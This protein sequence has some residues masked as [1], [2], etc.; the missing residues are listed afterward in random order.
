MIK[1]RLS[2]IIIFIVS[3]LFS[4][5][6]V[7]EP[8]EIV[9]DH[10]RTIQILPF[11][12]KTQQIRL[13]TD[14][15]EEV[16]NEF[17]KEGRLTV[18]S[19]NDADSS[20]ETSIIEYS[21]IPI[22]YDENFIAQEYKLK[23]ILNLKFNDHINRVKLWEDVREDLSGGIETSIK[24]YVGQEEEFAET[25]EEAKQRLIQDAA[26]QILQRTIYGWEK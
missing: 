2:I 8:I 18:L 25:E 21:K 9:P 10:I 16:T 20:L 26:K 6:G 14:L 11:K 24:Y 3:F 1:K 7:Y 4:G 12:N 15:Y 5:C 23:M 19:T 17:I 22:A 13:G